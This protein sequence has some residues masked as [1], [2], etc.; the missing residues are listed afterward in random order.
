MPLRMAIVIMR[1]APQEVGGVV[2]SEV[3]VM[4]VVTILTIP[5]MI[6]GTQTMVVGMT[7]EMMV[8]TP[9]LLQAAGG[10]PVHRE[11]AGEV[12]P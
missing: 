2:V 8:A 1:A 9:D 11:V 4:I 3:V 6:V 5:T 12:A 10:S 7:K